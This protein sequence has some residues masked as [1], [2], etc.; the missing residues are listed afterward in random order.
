MLIASRYPGRPGVEI[1][2]D[3]LLGVFA[4]REQAP[5]ERSPLEEIVAEG[6]ANPIGLKPLRD[7]VG[8]GRRVVLLSDDNTRNTPVRAIL[9][10]VLA[11]LRAGGLRD[12]DLTILVALGTHRLM[13]PAELA[14]KFGPEVVGRF[15]ILQHRFADEEQLADLGRTELGTDIWVN[16]AVLEADV[17]VGLGQVVPHRV[18]GYSGGSKIVQPGVC[19]AVTTG[20]THWLSAA[21]WGHEIL[22]RADNPVRRE[23]DEV[24]RRCNLAAIVNAVLDGAG[25]LVHLVY[26]EPVAAHRKACALSRDIFGVPIPRKAPIVVTDSHPADL[27]LWQGAKGYYSAELAVADGGV[28]IL[29][30]P[31]PEGVAVQHPEVTSFG[32][33]SYAEVKALVET[34]QLTDLT[35]AAH[36]VHV[37]RLVREKARGIIVSPGI[38][39]EEAERLNLGWAPNLAEAYEQAQSMVGASAEVMVLRN[40]GDILPL[41]PE[42]EEVA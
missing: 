18:A 6:L 15:R 3:R 28:V 25:R 29:E 11:E 8:R 39:R 40:G 42:N 14:A 7:L 20:Q 27:E 26:G 36:L 24:G 9:P 35:V 30:T 2:G 37:G 1:P 32:Y 38:G 16:R 5:G 33:R 4:P 19:G 22:G 31:C 21:F 41:P 10:G 34:A 23:M 12:T 17:V 13:T